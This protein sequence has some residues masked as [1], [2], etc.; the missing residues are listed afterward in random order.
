MMM[1][2]AII[3]HPWQ[4]SRSQ[5]T[6]SS[7]VTL[8]CQLFLI[9]TTSQGSS[10]L[11]VTQ[12]LRLSLRGMQAVLQRLLH[13]TALKEARSGVSPIHAN[14]AAPSGLFLFD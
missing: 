10:N 11:S 8:Q 1:M 9:H 6:I 4:H 5:Q 7:A 3:L 14:Q 12:S 2:I 13:P